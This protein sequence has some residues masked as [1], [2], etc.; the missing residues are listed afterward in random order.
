MENEDKQVSEI[1]T[2]KK[3]PKAFFFFIEK[4]TDNTERFV[5]SV[6]T[7]ISTRQWEEKQSVSLLP[8]VTAGEE[9]RARARSGLHD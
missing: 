3:E 8:G 2:Q 9:W 5:G 7:Q 1:T 4:I 6:P